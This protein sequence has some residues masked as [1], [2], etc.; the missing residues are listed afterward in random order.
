MLCLWVFL[1]IAAFSFSVFWY[2]GKDSGE[3]APSE[4]MCLLPKWWGSRSELEVGE[5]EIPCSP[6]RPTAVI[7][8]KCNIVCWLPKASC[9]GEM[10]DGCCGF[11][12][13]WEIFCVYKSREFYVLMPEEM[14]TGKLKK[15]RYKFNQAKDK[16]TFSFPSY[17][18][19][20]YNCLTAMIRSVGTGCRK[21]LWNC[22]LTYMLLIGDTQM[23]S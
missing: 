16:L 18:R 13:P 20:W 7:D 11:N 21:C 9:V 19:D 22:C 8:I 4:P 14:K 3:K 2:R 17:P 15:N 1:L 5:C 23:I 10:W 6:Q 12:A